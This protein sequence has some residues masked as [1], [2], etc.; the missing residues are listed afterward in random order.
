MFLRI[1]SFLAT[2]RPA[3]AGAAVIALIA[4]ATAA[5]RRFPT[6]HGSGS[7]AL[8]ERQVIHAGPMVMPVLRRMPETPPWTAALV[9]AG[10]I[11]PPLLAPDAAPLPDRKSAA[12]AE[13][14]RTAMA[15]QVDDAATQTALIKSP[16]AVA[17]PD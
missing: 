6:Y 13:A 2:I 1:Q 11:V 16:E 14:H 4:A 8:H 7:R 5:D 15:A 17:V 10:D 3:L 12:L 9:A